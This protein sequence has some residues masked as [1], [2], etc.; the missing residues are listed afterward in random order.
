MI[1]IKKHEVILAMG[2]V[3]GTVSYH[4]I[5]IGDIAVGK[6]SLLSYFEHGSF[7]ETVSTVGYEKAEKDV[8]LGDKVVRL[9]IFDP[10]GQEKYR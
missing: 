8:A 3:P 2:Q 4:A 10:A 6:S 5:I 9:K 1:I 7:Q